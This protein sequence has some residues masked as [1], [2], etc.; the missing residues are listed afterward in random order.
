MDSPRDGAGYAVF[1][2]I[3]DGMDTVDKI[4]QVKT[5]VKKNMPDVPVDAVVMT[6]VRK[7][8][9]DEVA[10]IKAKLGKK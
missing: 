7:A 9:A 3:V 10:A 8:N 2:R 6:E 5:T 4:E 1:G